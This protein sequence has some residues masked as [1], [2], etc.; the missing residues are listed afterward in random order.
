[1]GKCS[2]LNPE[3]TRVENWLIEDTVAFKTSPVE[4]FYLGEM[5][6]NFRTLQIF[7]TFY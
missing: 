3:G 2:S 1:M 5:Y 4:N 7:I 6:L